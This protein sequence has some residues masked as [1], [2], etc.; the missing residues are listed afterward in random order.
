MCYDYEFLIDLYYVL[1]TLPIGMCI[2]IYDMF[3]LYGWLALCYKTS[4]P[5]L[6]GAP[7]GD[8]IMKTKQCLCSLHVVEF[9]WCSVILYIYIFDLCVF[10]IVAIAWICCFVQGI[11]RNCLDNECPRWDELCGET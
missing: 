2:Y 11:A 8:G 7:S 9:R 3:V 1:N 10:K 6:G 5:L 4:A